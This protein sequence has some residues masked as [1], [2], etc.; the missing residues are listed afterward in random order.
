MVAEIEEFA[1][2]PRVEHIRE[3]VKSAVDSTREEV[4]DAVYS[5]ADEMAHT[6]KD[7]KKQAYNAGIKLRRW[8]DGMLD[9]A[10]TARHKVEGSIRERPFVSS[11]ALFTA[12]II[13][14]RVIAAKK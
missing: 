9:Q 6:A 14:A 4:E 8:V 5:K 12:G 11:F 2:S 10:D 7:L 1:A 3:T 13:T